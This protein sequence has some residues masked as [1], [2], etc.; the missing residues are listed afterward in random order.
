MLR[1][2]KK[3]CVICGTDKYSH[4]LTKKNGYNIFK[5]SKCGLLFV[6][7]QP[8][9]EFLTTR[10]YS[11]KGGYH[12]KLTKDL[13][14][15]KKFNVDLKKQLRTLKS[16]VKKGPLLDV[17]C[18]NGEFMWLARNAGY[19]PVGVEINKHT[20]EAARMNG[21]KVHM[22]EL[23]N[24]NFRNNKF[25]VIRAGEVIEH[26]KE[27]IRFIRECKRILRQKGMLLITTPNMDCF[28]VKLTMFLHKHFHLPWSSI[29]PPYHL[30]YFS[31]SNIKT[32]LEQEGFRIVEEEYAPVSLKYE[33]G[34]T[35]MFEHLR[36]KIRQGRTF[37]ILKQFISTILVSGV[38]LTVYVIDRLV[39]PLKK[40]DFN[41]RLYL[42]LE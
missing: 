1:K 35:L 33:L 30:F 3:N 26:L 40:K 20:A 5:C 32:L 23:E 39:T 38:Y 31:H 22:K 12:L 16:Y 42:S 7:P 18:S 8:S 41:M 29:T 19:D 28:F 14:H 24:A 4:M 6:Y 37:P 34:A 36:Q 25:S 10:V 27:P 21:L 13:A 2:N 9:K 15:Y 17:G 11:Q